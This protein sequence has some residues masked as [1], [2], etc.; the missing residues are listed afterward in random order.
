[1]KPQSV[2]AL[3][4]LAEPDGRHRNGGQAAVGRGRLAALRLTSAARFTRAR[5]H[6]D[7]RVEACV[8]RKSCAPLS[9]LGWS[10]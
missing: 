3:L 4:P 5:V 9:S 10:C 7:S 1:M 2:E 6:F 8:K